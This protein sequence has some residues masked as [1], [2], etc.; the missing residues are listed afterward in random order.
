MEELDQSMSRRT[1]LLDK[2]CRLSPPLGAALIRAR[3]LSWSPS[4]LRESPRL[5]LTHLREHG[6]SLRVTASPLSDAQPWIQFRAR[7]VIQ[8]SLPRKPRIIEFG[9]GGSTLYWLT[10][11][12]SVVSVEHDPDWAQRVHERALELGDAGVLLDLRVVEPEHPR[13]PRELVDFGT[14]DEQLRHMSSR[15]YVHA[16]DDVP[17]FSA[18]LVIIDGRARSAALRHAP[19][20]VRPSG[21]IVLD[22]AER[23]EY[24]GAQRELEDQ[25]W[26]WSRFFGPVPYLRHFSETAIARRGPELR[27]ADHAC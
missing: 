23:H 6:V 16:I 18:D 17:D 13:E 15:R 21:L 9:A 22:N 14:T 1:L 3:A 10:Q 12:A 11:G 5:L 2:L 8:Q 26:V 27:M 4:A 25:G 20:K 19:R 24:Q 7:D